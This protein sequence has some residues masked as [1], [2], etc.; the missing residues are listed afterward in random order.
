[1]SLPVPDKKEE[2]IILKILK[3]IFDPKPPFP[4][5]DKNRLRNVSEK[6]DTL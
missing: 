1:M 3:I 2:S 6:H 4:P 5:R